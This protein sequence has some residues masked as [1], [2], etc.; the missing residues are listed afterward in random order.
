[1]SERIGD[2]VKKHKKAIIIAVVILFVLII[3]FAGFKILV[4]AGS[5]KYFYNYLHKAKGSLATEIYIENNQGSEAL[6]PYSTANTSPQAHEV[7]ESVRVKDASGSSHAIERNID[8]SLPYA[9]YAEG[10]FTFRGNF[11]RALAP[12]SSVIK[13]KKFSRSTWSYSTGKILKSNGVDYWSGNGWTGQ[14][15]IAKWNNV[16]KQTMNLYDKAKEKQDLV[17]VIYPGMDG[18]I[19]FLDMETGEETRDPIHVGMT[20]KGTATLYPNGIP[21]LICGSG[22]A[23]TGQFG[24]NVSQRF[25]IYS[26]ID[27]SILYQGGFDDSFAPRIWHAY[28]SSPVIDPNAD[29]LIQPGENGVIYTLKLNTVYDEENG[30][31]TIN[32]SEMIDYTFTIENKY[33]EGGYLWGSECSAAAWKNYI[34]LG[35]NAGTVYCLDVNEMRMVWVTE[36]NEDINS[37][38]IFEED[39]ACRYLYVATTLKYNYD[40]HSMGAAAIYKLNAMTGEIIWKKPY[41]VQTVKGYAGGVLSTGALG[42]GSLSNYLFYSVS[43]TP[44]VEDGYLIALDKYTGDELWT[45]SLPMYSWSSTALTEGGDGTL[46]LLQGCQN[47]DL[48]LIDAQ[49]GKILDSLNF[50]AGIEATPVIYGNRIVLATRSEKI[51]GVELK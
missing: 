13:D 9:C 49:T 23:Q 8:L 7:K 42:T 20:F 10:I 29:I 26:L 14:P 4:K 32:P 40:S 12:A 28:D 50:G 36:V 21:M 33:A 44:G 38:P 3:L 6:T 24:E 19:H 27:G 41:E 16:Q 45:L 15:I 18:S 22:D 39:G 35:D 43:K 11:T 2:F 1:M 25:Y 31:L 34:F 48:L 46:Y 51:I 17:E 5:P 47:G 37:S 30:K